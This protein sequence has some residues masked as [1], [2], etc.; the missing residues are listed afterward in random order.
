M[1]SGKMK[2]FLPA[3]AVVFLSVL[4][5]LTVCAGQRDFREIH[6]YTEETL[7]T[8]EYFSTLICEDSPAL[9][10]A[11]NAVEEALPALDLSDASSVMNGITAL[12]DLRTA[13]TALLEREN[14]QWRQTDFCSVGGKVRTVRLS[15]YGDGCD[16]V[17]LTRDLGAAVIWETNGQGSKLYYISGD[18]LL[19]CKKESG[20]GVFTFSACLPM[21]EADDVAEQR[22]EADADHA[23]YCLEK[24]REL[25]HPTR[26]E[27][28]Y[29][30]DESMSLLTEEPDLTDAAVVHDLICAM[31]EM[32]EAFHEVRLYDHFYHDFASGYTID[33]VCRY[34]RL[35][36]SEFPT[37]AV[38]STD[39]R[40]AVLLH[41]G[42]D[43]YALS[44]LL[45]SVLLGTQQGTSG[46]TVTFAAQLPQWK[47]NP[48]GESAPLFGD[49]P[50]WE[51][52]R[53]A[54]W[55]SAQESI[56]GWWRK[57]EENL[58]EY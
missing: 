53:P 34:L 12:D 10:N 47:S 7:L 31:H 54:D 25:I 46:S 23:A 50:M 51:D 17:I 40:A 9:D 19:G 48:A 33:G 26:F 36:D 41:T 15:L 4:L 2:G 39:G 8:E 37:S 56:S 13:V 35:D 3:A 27:R 20:Q 21:T 45:D 28:L 18:T 58:A 29:K 38:V 57:L 11:D 52:R 24:A 30:A 16:T 32:Q 22:F 6:S 5:P 43:S 49:Y 44:F 55:E 1:A 14:G 42:G